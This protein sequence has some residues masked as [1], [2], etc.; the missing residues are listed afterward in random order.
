MKIF[1]VEYHFILDSVSITVLNPRENECMCVCFSRRTFRIWAY[2]KWIFEGQSYLWL[3]WNAEARRSLHAS[4]I[5]TWLIVNWHH[6]KEM[7]QKVISNLFQCC[8]LIWDFSVSQIP[9][10]ML[11]LE[12]FTHGSVVKA[13]FLI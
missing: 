2:L 12:L 13:I 9:F 7:T 1:G 5:W 10:C 6:V 3:V 11:T 8:W 4:H